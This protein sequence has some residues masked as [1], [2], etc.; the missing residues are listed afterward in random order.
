MFTMN[1]T[2]GFSTADLAVMNAA[3]TILVDSGMD[4]KTAHNFICNRWCN[5][6]TVDSLTKPR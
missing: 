2:E 1:N 5:A 6:A 3:F 4:E